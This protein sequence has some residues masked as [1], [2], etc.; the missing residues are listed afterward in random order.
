MLPTNVAY[1]GMQGTVAIPCA[2][3]ATSTVEQW[4]FCINKPCAIYLRH[5]HKHIQTSQPQVVKQSPCSS[6]RQMTS[7]TS[8]ASTAGR[9]DT[10]EARSY[11][12]KSSSLRLSSYTTSTIIHPSSN[13]L[14]SYTINT[15]ATGC[16]QSSKCNTTSDEPFSYRDDTS[17]HG[18]QQQIRLQSQTGCTYKWSS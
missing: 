8:F 5:V 9:S 7:Y 14:H 12:M 2:E 4:L 13:K 15:A 18:V 3:T 17:T 16:Q 1:S 6:S 10:L 11:F